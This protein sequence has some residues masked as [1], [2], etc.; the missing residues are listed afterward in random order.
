MGNSN[1]IGFAEI[2]ASIR[3]KWWVI[4]ACAILAAL[5]AFTYTKV[6][7]TPMYRSTV[8]MVI[9]NKANVNITYSDIQISNQL[10]KD[11]MEIIQNRDVLKNVAAEVGASVSGKISVA[12]PSGTRIVAVTVTDSDP[13]RAKSIADAVYKYAS[14]AIT[15]ALDADAVNMFETPTVNRSPVSPNVSRNTWLGALSGALLSAAVLVLLAIVNTRI[16]TPRDVEQKLGLTLLAA[17]PYNG[18][19][20]AN[21]PAKKRAG[22]RG[23]RA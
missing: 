22:K 13:E 5:A 19:S 16:T 4:L 20:D 10:V 21:R 9:L 23:G 15:E 8:K 12:N 2:L 18:N 17:I 1:E 7:V 3:K 6:A 11:S 14:A